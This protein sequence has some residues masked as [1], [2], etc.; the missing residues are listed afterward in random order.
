MNKYFST[1][2]GENLKSAQKNAEKLLGQ[3]GKYHQ[4]QELEQEQA[5][6]APVSSA[7]EPKKLSTA[8]PSVMTGLGPLAYH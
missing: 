6:Y 8:R 1:V 4:H 2:Q 3:N 7:A 5:C